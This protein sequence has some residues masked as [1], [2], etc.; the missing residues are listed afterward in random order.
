[1]VEKIRAKAS[2]AARLTGIVLG[3]AQAANDQI[4]SLQALNETD[5]LPDDWFGQLQSVVTG[6]QANWPPELLPEAT[7]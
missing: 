2:D 4:D 6:L 3:S 1:V 5:Q 7:S